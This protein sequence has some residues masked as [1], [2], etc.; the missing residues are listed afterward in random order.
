MRAEVKRAQRE[1]PGDGAEF[2]T[3]HK[4]VFSKALGKNAPDCGY[5][6]G[7]SG[8]EDLVHLADVRAGFREKSVNATRDLLQLFRNPFFEVLAS[9]QVRDG[10]AG[11][12]E[13]KD[14]GIFL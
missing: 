7:A 8:E 13:R 6:R 1:S 11:N 2:V 12:L 10:N 9:E 4:A 3:G 5:K 14:G